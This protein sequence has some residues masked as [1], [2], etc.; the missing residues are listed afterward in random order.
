M[1]LQAQPASI[2]LLRYCQ[3]LLPPRVVRRPHQV[4]VRQESASDSAVSFGAAAPPLLSTFRAAARI[5]ATDI[6]FFSDIS[7]SLH[8]S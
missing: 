8:R 7:K 5:S 1:A 4:Q 6:F 3:Y 2:S